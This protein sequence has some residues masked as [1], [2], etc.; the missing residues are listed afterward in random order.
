MVQELNLRMM[1]ALFGHG[2]WTAIVGATI[3]R[4]LGRSYAPRLATPDLALGWGIAVVLHAIFDTVASVTDSILPLVVVGVAGLLILRFFIQEAVA[5]ARFGADAPPPPPLARALR[6]YLA[7]LFQHTAPRAAASAAAFVSAAPGYYA[8]AEQAA[9]RA[10]VA[11]SAQTVQ[12]TP[13][14]PTRTPPMQGQN[15]SSGPTGAPPV[16]GATPPTVTQTPYPDAAPREF[17]PS[18]EPPPPLDDQREPHAP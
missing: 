3:W 7:H 2:I 10:F 1:L 12:A 5:R 4:D 18:P 8:E 14:D 11:F 16:P 13:H 9:V 17:T 6:N 15:T